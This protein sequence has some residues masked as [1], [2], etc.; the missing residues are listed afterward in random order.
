[1]PKTFH[2][3]CTVDDEFLKDVLVTAV[4]GG[5]NDWARIKRVHPHGEDYTS[6]EIAPAYESDEFNPCTIDLG[7]IITGIE[8]ALEPSAP[9]NSDILGDILRAVLSNDAGHI[10]ATDADAIVQLAVHGELVY[11]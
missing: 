6:A 4:E 1:M 9:L 11:G 2:I 10:D 3:A 8:R 5:I 7:T